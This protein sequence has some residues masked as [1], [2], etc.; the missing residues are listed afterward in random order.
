LDAVFFH[1]HHDECEGKYRQGLVEISRICT[2]CFA[3]KEDFFHC[4]G[5]IKRIVHE[6]RIDNGSL[7]NTYLTLFDNAVDQYLED[8]VI[9]GAEERTLARFIQF[10]GMPQTILNSNK[11]LEKMLQSKVIQ[12]IL[13]GNVPAPRIQISGDF[14]FLL[15]KGEHLVWLFRNVTLHRQKVKKEYAGR[16]HGMS[17]RIMK[18]VYYRIGGFKGNPIET[19][20]MQRIGNGSACF[21]DRNIY[22]AGSEKSLKIPYNKIISVNSYSNCIGVQKDG[23]ND[24]PI[25]LEDISGWFE[26]NVIVN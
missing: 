20:V 13:A 14:P 9:D 17:F 10:S 2:G 16:S 5:E 26:Y 23:T 6:S 4:D 15:G 1:S 21:T 8:G 3:T 7:E 12:D 24:K 19:T 22:F 18:G 11:S 25:F